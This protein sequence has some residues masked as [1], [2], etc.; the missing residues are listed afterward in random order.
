MKITMLGHSNVGKTTFMACMYAVLQSD[1]GGFRIIAKDEDDHVRL[2]ELANQVVDGIG[3]PR[4]T[5]HRSEYDLW[6]VHDDEPVLDFTWVDYR[7]G[8]LK[9]NSASEEAKALYADL[10]QSDGIVVFFDAEELLKNTGR[11]NKDVGRMINLLSKT[12]GDVEHPL[13][14]SFTLTK[15]DLVDD[16][17]AALEP[18]LPLAQTIARSKW[19]HGALVPTICKASEIVGV[20]LPTLFC[21]NIGIQAH[22]YRLS[23]AIE[24]ICE[25]AQVYERRSGILD[26]IG[27]W[28]NGETSYSE[29]ARRGYAEHNRQVSIHNYLVEP[30]NNLGEHVS[31]ILKF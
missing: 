2:I 16:L 5:D 11:R 13:P 28:F 17:D 3:Y 15:T 12:L 24:G 26:D 29:L 21:L 25:E 19:V 22:L 27:S 20:H 9:E 1:V 8:A 30:A 7:G 14:V 4:G 23:K 6:L 10:M 18:I 31:D